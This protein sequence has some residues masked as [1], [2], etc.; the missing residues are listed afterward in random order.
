MLIGLDVDGVCLDFVGP[1]LDIAGNPFP[2]KQIKEWSFFGMLSPKQRRIVFE[3]LEGRS[4]WDNQPK[5]SGAYEGIKL[6]RQLGHY[7]VFVTSPWRS[8]SQWGY[9]RRAVLEFDFGARD[10]DTIITSKKELVAPGLDIFVDDKIETLDK[11]RSLCD[12]YR[13]PASY[14]ASAS[15]IPEWSWDR[16]WL[17]ENFG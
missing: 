4:F 8:C 17:E 11:C 2:R 13:Y 12:V 16:K 7:I 9:W 1:V 10:G 3:A 15:H 6:L 14:N 5:I